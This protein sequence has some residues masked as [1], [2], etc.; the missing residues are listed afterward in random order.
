MSARYKNSIEYDKRDY[1]YI[2]E[3]EQQ[4]NNELQEED[5]KIEID[6][7]YILYV[8]QDKLK[9]TSNE[10]AIEIFDKLNVSDL[11]LFLSCYN[12]SFSV[13]M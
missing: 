13:N 6:Y 12:N 5:F 4:D 9:K 1:S 7:G 10:M 2:Y 3:D 11:R 8:I